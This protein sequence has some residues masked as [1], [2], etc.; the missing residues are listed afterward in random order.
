MKENVI[1]ALEFNSIAVGIEALDSMVKAALVR[2]LKAEI[3]CPGKYVILVTGDVASVD[4]SLSAG[5]AVAPACLI[6]ELFI[7]NLHE[8]IIPAIE[9]GQR[10]ELW[11]A[12]GLIEAFSIIAGIVAGDA[13][14]KEAE[15]WIPEIRLIKEMG[16]KSY[17]K[18]IGRIEAVEAGLK[19]GA[20]L[21]RARGL[22]CREVLIPQPHPEI[23][24]FVL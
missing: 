16:G 6:D 24:P 17:V 8:Q 3:I 7:P 19:A 18:M 23:R 9:G 15:I 5:K 1:G 11:D 12:L 14:A 4:A 21:V 10:L 20:A 2:I 13:A 22:L